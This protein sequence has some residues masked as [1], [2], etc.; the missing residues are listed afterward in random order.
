MTRP[1]IEPNAEERAEWDAFLAARSEKCRAAIGDLD[2][3][4]LYRY[5]EEPHERLVTLLSFEEPYD[6]DK[7]VTCTIHIGMFNGNLWRL[8][9]R[10]VFGIDPAMLVPVDPP[11]W[12]PDGEEPC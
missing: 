3:W 4:H 6:A 1:L 9:E 11:R 10:Q 5:G 7:P 2:P 8:F 12:W